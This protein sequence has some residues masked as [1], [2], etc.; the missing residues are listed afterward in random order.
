M[1]LSKFK[2]SLQTCKNGVTSV[3]NLRIILRLAPQ[4]RHPMNRPITIKLIR[5]AASAVQAGMMNM[6]I[7]RNVILI[8]SR[9]WAGT[10]LK[11]QGNII[12]LECHIDTQ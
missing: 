9:T 11:T 8:Q 10:N 2:L 5:S 4:S 1:P 7:G 3:P 12:G 6:V